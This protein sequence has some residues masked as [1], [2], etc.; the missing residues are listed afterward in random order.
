M[1]AAHAE[2]NALKDT[3]YVPETRDTTLQDLLGISEDL[4]AE[5]LLLRASASLCHILHSSDVFTRL[6]H[7][8]ANNATH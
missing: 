4:S 1:D 2:V 3:A 5:A 8:S 7:T 6:P